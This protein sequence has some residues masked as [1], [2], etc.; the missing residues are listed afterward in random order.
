[1][2][3][4]RAMRLTT[5]NI[6]SAFAVLIAASGCGGQS[7]EDAARVHGADVAGLFTRLVNPAL[8]Y[9][10][11]AHGVHCRFLGETPG[12]AGLRWAYWSCGLKVR[13]TV[14]QV[15]LAWQVDPE[16]PDFAVVNAWDR[17][18]GAKRAVCCVEHG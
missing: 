16:D 3:S 7:S 15:R 5:R 11:A 1:M 13:G 14:H 8:D 12:Q 2:M 18:T 4:R 17:E 6:G 9:G 10:P